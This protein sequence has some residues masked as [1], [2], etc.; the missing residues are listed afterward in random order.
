[1]TGQT[2]RSTCERIFFEKVILSLAKG[3]TP[4]N[5]GQLKRSRPLVNDIHN[6]LLADF[7]KLVRPG[8]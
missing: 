2:F 7:T 6:S 4:D 8:P 1:M 5:R 3:M